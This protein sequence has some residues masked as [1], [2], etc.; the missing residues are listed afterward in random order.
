M[1]RFFS[2]M[3]A[4]LVK[5]PFDN[6]EW[7]FE[8]KWDGYRALAFIED[9][10]V[11]L[12]SRTRRSWNAAFPELIKDLEKSKQDVILDGEIVVLDGHGKSHFQLLQNYQ[13]SQKGNLHYYLFDILYIEGKDLRELPLIERK[14]ALKKYL[15]HSNFSLVRESPYIEDKG[16]LFYKKAKELQLEGIVGKKISSGYHSCRSQDWVKIKTKM[17]QEVVIGGFTEPRGS[18]KKFG[19]LIVGL[20]NDKNEFIY[21]GHVGGGFNTKLL[22]QVYEQMTP[23]I[24]TKCPFKTAPKR[25]NLATW[26]KP[27]LVC[28]VAFA[29]WTEDRHLRQPI[30]QGIRVD[31]KP[32]E[33]RLEVPVSKKVSDLSL[34]NE[35]K[36]YWPDEQYTKGDL[37]NYYRKI[38]PFILPYLKK[39]PMMLHRYP[40]GIL[41]QNF[42]QK[43]INFTS[44]KWL[45]IYPIQHKGSLVHYVGINN[46]RSL[47]YVINLGSIDLHPFLSTY[48]QL[49]YPD[50][51]LIDLDPEGIP[52]SKVA[53]VA[54]VT[55]E[56][57]EKFGIKNLCKTSGATGLHIL[58][59]LK[60]KY[61]YEQSRRF[62]EIIG[63]L[64]HQ[65]LP[66]ITSLERN[67][68]KRQKK[69]YLD[70]LQNSRGQTMAAPYSVRPRPGAPVST[71]LLWS[72]VN[73]RLNPIEFNIK[74]IA[75]RLE[76]KGDL[77]KEV[78]G[79][80]VDIKKALS[81]ISSG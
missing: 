65:Q 2:P 21:A 63:H 79:A 28:E 67:P 48:D 40:E 15:A 74:T 3:L 73:D 13:K 29:E 68:K 16:K 10:H 80:G 11:Q 45:K 81:R 7:L 64:V 31:K 77:F 47:L 49:E 22:G 37:L 76:A 59:P 36:I 14:K 62:A 4:T 23:L 78:L 58:I 39:R 71:P 61:T 17:R 53:E 44:P 72:E 19:A 42:Y 24:Q 18:R 43:D 69:V 1:L 57:L 60:R 51:C 12:V 33:V 9:G 27:V 30:F 34:S 8:T 32:K 20:Y 66:D 75:H 35:S 55:H 54:L 50:F 41:G 38:A 52:F 25:H 5:E 46:L 56:L 6:K 26:V 70:Y